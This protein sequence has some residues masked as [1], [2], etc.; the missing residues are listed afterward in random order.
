MSRMIILGRRV[1]PS[2]PGALI[3]MKSKWV[4]STISTPGVCGDNGTSPIARTAEAAGGGTGGGGS[5]GGN[6]GEGRYM[7]KSSRRELL[8]AMWLTT[9]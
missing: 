3:K 7:K 9:R 8:L 5:V 4:S 2:H 1:P 6:S